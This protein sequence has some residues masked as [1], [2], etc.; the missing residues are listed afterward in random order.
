MN[1]LSDAKISNQDLY[2]LYFDF[3]SPF[4]TIDHDK[5]LCIMHDLG[6][7]QDAIQTVQDLYTDVTTKVK[8]PY[9]EKEAVHIDRGSIQGDTLSPFLFLVFIEPLLR[10]LQSSGRGYRYGCLKGSP[11]AEHTTSALAYADDLAAMTSKL[12]DLKRQ[13]AKIASFTAWSGMKVN[14][15]KCAVTGVQYGDAEKIGGQNQLCQAKTLKC[16][17]RCAQVT[18]QGAPLPFHH[19]DKEPYKYLGVWLTP[20]IELVA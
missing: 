5:L 11:H 7:P 12:E 17:K 15:S 14:C 10:W 18:I 20:K 9:A 13:A 4:N 6:F 16:C 1:I 8:L 19:P 2:I 3:S